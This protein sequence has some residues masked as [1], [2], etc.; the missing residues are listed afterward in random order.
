[1]SNTVTRHQSHCTCDAIVRSNS[2]YRLGHYLPNSHQERLLSVFGDSADNI[3]F[4]YDTADWIS[5]FN[6]ESCDPMKAHPFCSILY[7]R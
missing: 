7:G 4:R 5:A 1:M 6:N 3:A 2:D